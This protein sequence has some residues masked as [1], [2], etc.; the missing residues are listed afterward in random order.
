MKETSPACIQGPVCVGPLIVG[1]HFCH[2]LQ[3]AGLGEWLQQLQRVFREGPRCGRSTKRK[4]QEQLD[5]GR[6]LNLE[7]MHSQ[8]HVDTQPIEIQHPTKLRKEC[9]TH[10]NDIMA[11][12][13]HALQALDHG[14]ENPWC[15]L[16]NRLPQVKGCLCAYTSRREKEKEAISMCAQANSALQ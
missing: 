8:I 5:Q 1:S 16:W 11:V 4:D 3:E 15:A 6:W 9:T 14:E 2:T 13:K 10:T 12:F 7:C